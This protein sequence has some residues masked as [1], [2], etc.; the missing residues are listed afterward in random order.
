MSSFRAR[1]MPFPRPTACLLLQEFWGNLISSR[2]SIKI[3][4][5]RRFS[6]VDPFAE[7]F[8]RVTD[9]FQAIECSPGNGNHWKRCFRFQFQGCS[10][11]TRVLCD[12]SESR[13]SKVASGPA[14]KCANRSEYGETSRFRARG[15]LRSEIS[16]GKQPRMRT[17]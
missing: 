17:S 3:N 11:C 8:V 16:G 4:N 9:D 13:T 14:E 7:P 6:V 10:P 15:R 1:R 12:S 5:L 2:F